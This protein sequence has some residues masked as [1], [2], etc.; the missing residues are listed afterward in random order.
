MLKD[1]LANVVAIF[2][3][4]GKKYVYQ[5]GKSLKHSM[6]WPIE[7]RSHTLNFSSQKV[8]GMGGG[9]HCNGQTYGN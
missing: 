6:Q 7:N 4:T 8:P 2:R 3:N 1:L 5:H 9:F